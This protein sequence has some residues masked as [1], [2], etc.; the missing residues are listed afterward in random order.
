MSDFLRKGEPP[1]ETSTYAPEVLELAKQA[2]KE[3]LG[4]PNDK[5]ISI[6]FG[7]RSGELWLSSDPTLVVG[8]EEL[9]VDGK[10]FYIGLFK[11]EQK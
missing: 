1:K 2:A 10:R 6:K 11:A 5:I 7:H 3:L 9:T 4:N 8:S